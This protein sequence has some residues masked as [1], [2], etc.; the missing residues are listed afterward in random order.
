M[1]WLSKTRIPVIVQVMKRNM[2]GQFTGVK[3]MIF[4]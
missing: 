1:K 2:T 4:W 3:K